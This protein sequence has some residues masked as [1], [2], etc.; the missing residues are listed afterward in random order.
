MVKGDGLTYLSLERM[1]GVPDFIV[2]RWGVGN[3]RV[4]WR[5]SAG[6]SGPYPS[7]V[8]ALASISFPVDEPCKVGV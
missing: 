5:T 6:W 1:N 4:K 7:K 3:W 2:E 8:V